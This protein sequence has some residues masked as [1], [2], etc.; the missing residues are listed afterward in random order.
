MSR[1][2]KP[3]WLMVF[4]LAGVIYGSDDGYKYGNKE[5][6]EIQMNLLG[7]GEE[8][9]PEKIK[10]EEETRIALLSKYNAI[11]DKELKR[12]CTE[13]NDPYNS[14]KVFD[15]NG[16]K[17]NTECFECILKL[18]PKVKIPDNLEY[19][20]IN[21]AKLYDPKNPQRDGYSLAQFSANTILC[22]LS[23]FMWAKHKA[24]I[25]GE[26]PDSVTRFAIVTRQILPFFYGSNALMSII[27]FFVTHWEKIK[28]RERPFDY[29]PSRGAG[30]QLF[31]AIISSI[32][33]WGFD[34]HDTTEKAVIIYGMLAQ[35]S[36]WYGQN[37]G[38]NFHDKR[39]VCAWE[40]GF[41]KFFLSI[42]GRPMP[43]GIL[44]KSLTPSPYVNIGKPAF[45]AFQA[46]VLLQYFSAISLLPLI[47]D[48]KDVGLYGTGGDLM[49]G[50]NYAF[51]QILV[52]IIIYK[53]CAGGAQGPILSMNFLSR[54]I[55][56]AWY[57]S[58]NTFEPS[59]KFIM[60]FGSIV[61]LAIY[62]FLKE[63]N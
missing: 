16:N 33:Y 63:Y 31:I 28:V 25:G 61:G 9:S 2:R 57:A 41:H 47:G 10:K 45:V 26:G 30:L 42:K 39:Y 34:E 43:Q 35:V 14:D 46:G 55:V 53:L 3:L 60:S 22:V 50:G 8:V 21:L 17:V 19:N 52:M 27:H 44:Q 18:Y 5:D 11:L 38:L 4:I 48:A 49:I 13:C 51:W 1:L 59:T 36:L 15:V 6:S 62:G 12:Y 32:S 40:F 37:L 29:G 56:I 24:I 54:A 7:N 58:L 20:G 23:T